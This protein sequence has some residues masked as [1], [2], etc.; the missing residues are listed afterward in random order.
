MFTKRM[1]QSTLVLVLLLSTLT[2][3]HSSV[4]AQGNC[5]STYTVQP[6][7]WLSSIANYCG[8]SLS[9]L[10]AANPWASRYYYIYPGQIL[11]IPG[12]GG[13]Y[14]NRYRNGYSDC[15]PKYSAYYGK[16]YVVCYGDTLSGIAW[17]YGESLSYMEWHNKITDADLIYAGQ[18]IW[19]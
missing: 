10:Y 3:A 5:G 19:P 9:A 4:S 15:G 17:R 7:D 8:V 14:W 18:F 2:V 1:I 11:V 16:Y 12:A 6:G 13:G